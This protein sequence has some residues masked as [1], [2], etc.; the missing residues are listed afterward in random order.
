MG[1][2]ALAAQAR[3]IEG[4]PHFTVLTV[5]HG[6]RKA[7][8][9]EAAQ[10]AAQC[11]KLNLPHVSLMADTNLG[12]SDFQQQARN[13][14][15]RLMS[16]WCAE[17]GVQGLVVAHHRDDQAETVLMRMAHGSGMSG[18]GGMAPRQLLHT[19]TAPLLLLRPLLEYGGA[20]VKAL[21]YEAGLPVIDDPSNYDSQFERVRWRRLLP[22]LKAEG[23]GA[24]RLAEIAAEMRLLQAALDKKLTAWLD[25]YASWHDY[26]VLTLPRTEFDALPLAHKQRFIGRFVQYFGQHA[27]PVK[28]R[29]TDRLVRQIEETPHGGA[30]VGGLHLRWRK[31]LVFLGRE[32]AACPEPVAISDMTSNLNGRFDS[33]FDRRFALSG[34]NGAKHLQLG[35]LGPHGVAEMSARGLSFDKAV[36][37]AYY[38][39]LPGIFD[40]DKLLQCPLLSSSDESIADFKLH[41]VFYGGFYRDIIAGGQG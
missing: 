7:A 8:V 31:S 17:H 33:H 16:V 37:A 40:G 35:A 29:K 2:L 6:L 28:Q 15:Y 21:A 36:P 25:H 30:S 13:M 18:L 26:G 12:M 27:H 34:T 24:A 23:L 5:N 11:E 9:A 32:A 4:A 22:L 10:V 14:R 3:G 39:A 41:S 1:L 20:E 38:A 19:E